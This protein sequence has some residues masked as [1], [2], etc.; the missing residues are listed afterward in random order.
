[1]FWVF[2]SA[3][4]P[5]ELASLAFAALGAADDPNGAVDL[6][7]S[8]IAMPVRAASRKRSV[9]RFA[10]AILPI[11]AWLYQLT[12]LWLRPCSA[13]SSFADRVRTWGGADEFDLALKD[14]ES[15]R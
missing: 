15:E 10:A 8:S 9:L 1:M 6:G 14:A 7:E 5:L 2:G 11:T 3:V 12:A 13:R 4:W